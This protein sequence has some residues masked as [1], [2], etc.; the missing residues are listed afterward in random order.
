MK[1]KKLVFLINDL[2]FFIS[3]RLHIAK[4]A[5]KKGYDVRIFTGQPASLQMYNSYKKINKKFNFPITET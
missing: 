2:P 1:K 5:V 3:H 4:N